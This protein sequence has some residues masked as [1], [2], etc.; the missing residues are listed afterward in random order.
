[1]TQ[2]ARLTANDGALND[3]FGFSVSLSA[4]GSTA[5]IGAVG[6]AIGQY[7]YQGSSY[8]FTRNGSVWNQQMRLDPSNGVANMNF[9]ISSALS[10]DGNTAL[11]GAPG[12]T[13]NGYSNQ[14]AAYVFTHN[15]ANWTQESILVAEKG[16][17]YGFGVSTA[18]SRDGNTA[19]VGAW[20]TT[21]NG[22]AAQGSAYI[23]TR[24]NSQWTQQTMLLA[25][26]GAERTYFGTSV[27]LSADGNTA[28]A[29]A[30]SKTFGGNDSQGAVYVYTRNGSVWS[31]QITLLAND[32]TQ[33][34]DFGASIGLTPDGN[35]VLIGAPG[36]D[37]EYTDQ[38][39]VYVF[40]RSRSNWNQ[41]AILTISDVGVDDQFGHSV[42][43]SSDGKI[44]LVGA[45]SKNVDGQDYHGVAYVF[46]RGDLNSK[47]RQRARLIANDGAANDSFGSSVALSADG[48]TALVGASEKTVQGQY[49]RGAAYVFTRGIQ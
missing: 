19:L 48:D 39:A 43:I 22:H 3:H 17:I 12:M 41:Q 4:D 31:P 13:I 27:A 10:A 42:A 46:S 32:V 44:G 30:R 28:L 14:G 2:Q 21:L 24:S 20:G 35:T 40:T 16:E 45:I 25:N 9:G 11:V 26:D 47:W 6:K 18:L 37:G 23:F 1:V 38:G 36:K 7:D 15:G 34:D 29:S 33:G 5:L 8:V 49:Y